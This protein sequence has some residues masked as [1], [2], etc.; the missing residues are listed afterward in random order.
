MTTKALRTSRDRQAGTSLPSFLRNARTRVRRPRHSDDEDHRA[1]TWIEPY[2]LH[3]DFLSLPGLRESFSPVLALVKD[4][5]YHLEAVHLHT[6]SLIHQD[7]SCRVGDRP[8]ESLKFLVSLKNR[9]VQRVV[10]HKGNCPVYSRS[11]F[12]SPR[13]EGGWHQGSR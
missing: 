4:G 12:V 6:I 11:L 8:L 9:S 13:L 2:N 3:L 10:D 7:E 1:L 5:P